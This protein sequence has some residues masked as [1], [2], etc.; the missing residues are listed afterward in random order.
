LLDLVGVIIF[1]LALRTP[2]L[3]LRGRTR[4]GIV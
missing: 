2:E 4:K 1:L 3:T